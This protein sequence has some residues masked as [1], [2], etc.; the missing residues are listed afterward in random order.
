MPIGGGDDLGTARGKVV[1]GSELRGIEQ[2]AQALV[3]FEKQTKSTNAS[4]NQ[5]ATVSAALGGALALGLG[6]AAKS[7]VSFESQMLAVKAVVGPTVEEFTKLNDLAIKIGRDTAFSAREGASALEELGKAGVSIADILS[8]AAD[9]A[10]ALA[11]AA[12]IGI[13]EAATLIANSL[14]EFALAGDQAGKVA[15]IFANVANKSASDAHDFGDALQYVGT[16]AHALAIPLEDVAAAIAV[17]ADQGISGSSA[18]TSLN[19][20]LTSLTAPTKEAAALMKNLGLVTQDQQGN[21]IGLTSIIEQLAAATDGLGNAEKQEIIAKLFGERGSRAINAL[22]NTQTKELEAAGKGWGDYQDAMKETGTAATAAETRLSGVAGAIESLKGA[23]EVAQIQ[24]GSA[25]APTIKATAEALTGLV[26]AFSSLSPGVQSVVAGGAALTATL[27]IGAA[28]AAKTIVMLRNL[29]GA[30]AGLSTVMQ[31]TNV[32]GAQFATGLGIAAAAIAASIAI[33]QMVKE[34]NAAIKGI[35]DLDQAVSSLAVTVQEL[36]LTGTI[37]D[38][39]KSFNVQ[40]V[41]AA[42]DGVLQTIKDIKAAAKDR[43][44]SGFLGLPNLQAAGDILPWVEGNM[45]AVGKAS[46]ET[47]KQLAAVNELF[48]DPQIDSEALATAVLDVIAAFDNSAKT[49]KDIEV[50][51][52]ALKAL[53]DTKSQFAVTTTGAAEASQAEADAADASAAELEAQQQA[54]EDAAKAQKE[55]AETIDGIIT[56]SLIAQGAINDLSTEL[57]GIQKG[58]TDADASASE[59]TLALNKA[60]EVRL[61]KT[62]REAL[63]LGIALEQTDKQ[64]GQVTNSIE[65]N[66]DDWGMWQSRIGL[67]TNVLGGNTDALATLIEQ[68]QTGKISQEEFNAAIQG[69]QIGQFEKLDALYQQGKISLEQYN[70]AKDAGVFLLQ[71]SAGGMQDESGELVDNVILLAEYVKAHDDAA[72][73]VDRLTESQKQFL[74]ATKSDVGTEFLNTLAL[75]RSAGAS[76]EAVTKFIFDSSQ[77]DPVIQAIAEDL[78]LIPKKVDVELTATNAHQVLDD[79]NGTADVLTTLDGKVVEVFVETPEDATEFAKRNAEELDGKEVTFYLKGDRTPIDGTIEN[80]TTE[81]RDPIVFPV[82]VDDLNPFGGPKV[83]AI[84]PPPAPDP[85]P[86]TAVDQTQEGI[87]AA[88]TSLNSTEQIAADA[89]KAAGE[90]YARELAAASTSVHAAITGI[91]GAVNDD[92]GTL[93]VTSGLWGSSVGANFVVA[94]VNAITGHSSEVYNAA[95]NMAYYAKL[96]AQAGLGIHSPSQAA[97]DIAS[98]FGQTFVKTVAGQGTDAQVAG[99]SFAQQFLSQIDPT[100]GLR[101]LLQPANTGPFRQTGVSPALGAAGGNTTVQ[102]NIT[103]PDAGSPEATGRAVVTE[104]FRTFTRLN[105]GGAVAN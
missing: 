45:E 105:A 64:L 84:E 94:F 47:A 100:P 61:T 85:V 31:K 36:K 40:A 101:S 80:I 24:L 43:E 88:T 23:L 104:L 60:G 9:G 8:G 55:F 10:V 78:G 25:L 3:D 66:Q 96:G 39:F 1:I 6:V 7:F 44:T 51:N 92:F 82:T 83:P 30:Y 38:A 81:P 53:I 56:N 18:G 89:G 48:Q 12:G 46:E 97:I 17:M 34:S 32:S 19:A 28:A 79:L 71:R 16:K 5:F 26:N 4:L 99:Q 75:L 86:I 52:S 58:F 69:G 14:N 90:A 67:V 27:L 62:N 76:N 15:D 59:L 37:D 29:S 74:A 91:A 21:F 68:L 72:G 42:A 63:E 13:P 103:I 98:N 50:M 102:A 11:A 35:D 20:A 41:Q 73:A 57:D 65:N 77:A 70:K 54:A 49:T 2:G 33:N 22:L 87:D 95:F 93:A